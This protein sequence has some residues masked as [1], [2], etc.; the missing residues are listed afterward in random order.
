[1]PKRSKQIWHDLRKKSRFHV[2]NSLRES[3]LL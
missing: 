3:T 1:M 2:K